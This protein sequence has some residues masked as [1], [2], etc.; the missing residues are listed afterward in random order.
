MSV[1][2]SALSELMRHDLAQVVHS[3]I[4]RGQEPERAGY[5]D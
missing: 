1:A 2:N 3:G 4:G 5:H